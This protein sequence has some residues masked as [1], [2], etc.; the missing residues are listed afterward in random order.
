MLAFDRK[1]LQGG[2]VLLLA[3]YCGSMR[4]QSVIGHA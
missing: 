1:R 2:V 3:V 4:R